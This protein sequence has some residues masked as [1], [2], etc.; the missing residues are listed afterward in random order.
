MP[1][2]ARSVGRNN[3]WGRGY[4]LAPFLFLASLVFLLQYTLIG[5][6]TLWSGK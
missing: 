3:M 4:T 6:D 5:G 1:V 2:L